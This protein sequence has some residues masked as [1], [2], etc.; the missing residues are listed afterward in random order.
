M[1]DSIDT[2]ID[3]NADD[4]DAYRKRNQNAADRVVCV[5]LLIQGALERGDRPAAWPLMQLVYRPAD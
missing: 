3:S 4:F 5:T 1:S 2:A